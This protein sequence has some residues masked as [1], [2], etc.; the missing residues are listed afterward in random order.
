MKVVIADDH[1]PQRAGIRGALEDAGFDVLAEVGDAKAAVEAAVEYRPD[2][3]LLDIHMPGSGIW[4]AARIT[5]A[6][7]ETAVVMLTVSRDDGDLFAALRAGAAGYLLKDTDPDRLPRALEGVLNGE[8]ALPRTLVAR[9]MDEFRTQGRG[10][11]SLLGADG[12]SK[13][14][15]REIEILELLREGLSTKDIAER[16][17]VTPVTVRTHIASLLKKLKVPDRAAAVRLIEGDENS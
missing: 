14:T 10:G 5:E 12:R 2:V 13:L 4:A 11:R 7:P 8:A 6:A 1:P 9:L 17:F 15:S 3:A 16:L